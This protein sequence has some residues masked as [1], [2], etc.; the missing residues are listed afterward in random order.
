VDP[1]DPYLYF[2]AYWMEPT[3]IRARFIE[4]LDAT[5]AA[6]PAA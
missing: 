5:P 2:K 3:V 1:L 6:V 4:A